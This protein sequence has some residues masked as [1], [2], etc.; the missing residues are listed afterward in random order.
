VRFN[1]RENIWDVTWR[2]KTEVGVNE[3]GNTM[4]SNIVTDCIISVKTGSGEKDWEVLNMGRS[5][6]HEE[7]RFEKDRGR[8]ISLKRAMDNPMFHK[9][10]RKIIWESYINRKGK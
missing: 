10:D 3:G 9:E 7:D 8:K 2:Y 1:I 5:K 4:N 6:C